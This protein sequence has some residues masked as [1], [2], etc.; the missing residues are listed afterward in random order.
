MTR[1]SEQTHLWLTLR[2]LLRAEGID[3]DALSVD[4]LADA[5]GVGRGTAQ[6]IKA[7]HTNLTTET[8]N[9]LAER[10]G[11]PSGYMSEGAAGRVPDIDPQLAKGAATAQRDMAQYDRATF[12]PMAM[13]LAMTLDAI[14]D[15]GARTKAFAAAVEIGRAHV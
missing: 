5:L 4:R 8:V 6:R 11:V 12:S 14:K 9:R 10:F 7:G 13:H 2:R 15:Q 3:A 1:E